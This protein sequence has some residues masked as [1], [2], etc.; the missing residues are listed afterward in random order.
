MAWFIV[1][2][3]IS[4]LVKAYVKH[5]T[6]QIMKLETEL[7]LITEN[8]EDIQENVEDITENVEDITE[9]VEEMQ[10]NVNNITEN[11]DENAEKNNSTK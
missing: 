6:S 10:E 3:R 11:V 4:W 8:V 2:Q 1:E 5:H 9:N 7:D